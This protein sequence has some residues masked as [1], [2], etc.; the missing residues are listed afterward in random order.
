ML[1]EKIVLVK[2]G[3]NSAFTEIR[4]HLVTQAQLFLPVFQGVEGT[5][6]AVP[7]SLHLSGLLLKGLAG[8]YQSLQLVL[9]QMQTI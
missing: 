1:H 7:Q 5:R 6:A 8:F 2:A 3:L 4:P 9:A